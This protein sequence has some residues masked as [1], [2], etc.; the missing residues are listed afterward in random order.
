MQNVHDKKA[1]LKKLL[2]Q[3]AAKAGQQTHLLSYGQQALWFLHQ[4]NPDN[5][6]YN[7]ALTARIHSSVDIAAWKK[8]CQRLINRHPVLRTTYIL[9]GDGPRQKVHAFMPVHFEEIDATAKNEAGLLERVNTTYSIPFDLENG[10]ICRIYLFKREI[11]D[12]ILLFNIHHIACDGFST[13]VILEELKNLY[14]AE[15]DGRKAELPK[16]EKDYTDFVSWQRSMLDGEKGRELW[17]YWQ[18]QLSGNLAVLELPTDRSR[19]A[20]ST[21]NG[22]SISVNF[23]AQLTESLRVFSKEQG[24]TLFVTLASAFQTLLRKY[25]GQ[26]DIIIGTPTTGRERREFQSIVGYFVNPVSLRADFS[27]NPTF[28][29]FLQNNKN[30]IYSAIAH[31]DFPFPYMVEKLQVQRDKNRTPVF[32]AFFSLLKSQ[33]DEAVQAVMSGAQDAAPQQ[34]GRLKISAYEIDQQEGQ[35]DLTMALTESKGAITGKLKYNSDIFEKES[36]E[37][38]LQHY[39]QLLKNIVAQPNM[40]INELAVLTEKEQHFL[41]VEMNQNTAPFPEDKCMHQIF[42]ARAQLQ[43]ATLALSM[44]AYEGSAKKAYFSYGELEDKANQ[45]AHFLIQRGVGPEVKVGICVHRS[46][47]M[48][49]AILGI[50]KAGGAYVPLDPEYPEERLA[51]IIKDADLSIILTHRD[52]VEHLP[53]DDNLQ[54]VFMDSDWDAIDKMSI[55]RPPNRAKPN[56]LA[57]IIYTS[58]STGKPKGVLIEHRGVV[59]KLMNFYQ[60]VEFTPQHRFTLL[61]SY[62]FDA[63]IGQMFMPLCSGSPLFLLPKDQQNDPDAFWDFM[64]KNDVN[65]LYTVASFLGPM[66]DTPKDISGL[67]IKCVFLGAEVFPVPVY[68]KIVELT[69]SAIDCKYVRPYRNYCELCNAHS[70]RSTKWQYTVRTCF[71]KLYRL[72]I[73]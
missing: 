1:L 46:P 71:T 55:N 42:E 29:E 27:D 16:I 15:L 12:Y 10:P 4:N 44:P 9:E 54:L 35:F 23:D 49:V 59:N 64:L 13:W 28:A 41:A 7:V 66:L 40:P 6:A 72:C 2:E 8:A 63:S 68:H 30:T 34:W 52:S 53:K 19:P 25:S 32:Q 11:D 57:Y 38:I 26:D 22:A 17:A 62:A 45:L 5:A 43:P 69:E 31:Q 37:R 60:D 48:V 51:Y 14:A 65:V 73:R 3:K 50:L 33:G 56:N 47:G 24:A 61:A 36:I 20:V 18:S 39:F 58:G 70:K 21:Q 67:N